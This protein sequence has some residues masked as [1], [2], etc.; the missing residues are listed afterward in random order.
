LPL[1]VYG[2]VIYDN[3]SVGNTSLLESIET[4]AKSVT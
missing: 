2:D 1:L 3:C 4:A